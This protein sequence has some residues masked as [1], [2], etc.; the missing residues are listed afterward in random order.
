M[1]LRR[2]PSVLSSLSLSLSL[3]A[4]ILNQSLNHSSSSS[5]VSFLLSQVKRCLLQ[6]TCFAYTFRF[7]FLLVVGLI[8][9]LGFP[10]SFNLFYVLFDTLF[11]F[12]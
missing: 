5:S 6:L 9:Q 3:S 1:P 11:F 2:V 12:P 8:K 7:I 4:L 10:Q